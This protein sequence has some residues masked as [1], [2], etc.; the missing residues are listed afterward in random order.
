MALAD[1]PGRGSDAKTLTVWGLDYQHPD[2]FSKVFDPTLSDK[3]LVVI[4]ANIFFDF[5]SE[6][7]IDSE[8]SRA[9]IADW[10]LA[11]IELCVTP[12]LLNEIDRQDDAAVR[13]RER[14]RAMN[15][16]LIE[17]SPS[18]REE[19]EIVLKGLLPSPLGPQDESDLRQLAYA[20]AGDAKF[21]VTRDDYLLSLADPIYAK[22]GVW[23]LRPAE[24][25][26]HLDTLES[27][28]DYLPVRLA[29]TSLSTRLITTGEL[30]RLV[31]VF[32]Q[33][34]AGETQADLRRRILRFMADPHRYNCRVIQDENS[35]LLALYVQ[36]TEGART[37][38]DEVPIF[39]VK[40][41]TLEKTLARCLLTQMHL[42]RCK[43]GLKLTVISDPFL[44]PASIAALSD[45]GFVS[46]DGAWI[47]V[48]VPAIGTSSDVA[49][50]LLRFA[51]DSLTSTNKERIEQVATRVEAITRDQPILAVEIE[52]ALWPVK[53]TNFPMS[54]YIVPIQPA[55]AK[56]L[57][58]EQLARQDLFGAR[59]DLALQQ[60]G[61][62]YRK[63]YFGAPIVP[64]RILWYVSHADGFGGSGM[65]RACSILEEVVTGKPKDLF[66]RFRRLGVYE[67][68]DVYETAGRKIDTNIMAL[69]FGHTETLEQPIAW[70]ALKE[71]L[72]RRGVKTNVRSPVSIT[73]DTFVELYRLGRPYAKHI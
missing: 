38:I 28:T 22:F 51:K 6:D 9:L 63:N 50:F 59:I 48:G 56:D 39:R 13:H 68:R 34:Q 4:D 36:A 11:N 12:E 58:D 57:F 35:D 7:D 18:A 31:N 26:I 33:S 64:S 69:R 54:S 73:I 41:F 20:I 72:T 29:G 30:E 32:Q 46:S 44:P 43:D 60:E 71:V 16:R 65:L 70:T 37:D 21:F 3:I 14:K 15:F 23:V 17:S 52:K 42:S 27:E 19:A 55:W 66:R 45:S 40:R 49:R 53:I 62:Y 67:W 24:L 5:V 47:K 1:R 8:E 2:L 25:V 61:V 10:M